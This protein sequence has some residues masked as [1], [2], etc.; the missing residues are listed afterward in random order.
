VRAAVYQP[1]G[2]VVLEER[3]VPAPGPGEVLVAMRACGICGSDLMGWYVE[4]RAPLVLGHEPVGEVVAAGEAVEAPLPKVGARVFVHHHVPCGECELCR[5]GRDTLC[6]TFRAT[7]IHPGGFSERILV[8]A[9][10]AARDLLVVPESVSDAAATLIEPLACCVRGLRRAKVGRET[11]LLVIG[12]GQM[13]LLTALG[14]LAAG[15]RVAVAE[16]LAARRD[17]ATSLGARGIEPEPE[18]AASTLGGRPTV[19]MLATGAAAAWELALS[20]A[21]KGAV[22]Q[23]FAPSGPGESRAFDV[24]DVFFRELEIQASYSAG[25]HDTRFALQLIAGGAV[26]AERLVTHRFPLERTEEALAA[27]RSR[28]GVKVIVTSSA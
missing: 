9:E 3:D 24:D 18:A 1:G 28:E 13:G 21:D 20:A 15:A 2:A 11:R 12:G 23:L 7:R 5:R 6:E 14:G 10:N 27:A 22:V 26:P 4:P 8:P 17:L 16:P 19:V 25:P